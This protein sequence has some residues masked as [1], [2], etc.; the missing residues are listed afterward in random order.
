MNIK[1]SDVSMYF[2]LNVQII[3]NMQQNQALR[4]TAP[5]GKQSKANADTRYGKQ[6]IA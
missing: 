3:A 1:S 4:A 5:H 6:S 2:S